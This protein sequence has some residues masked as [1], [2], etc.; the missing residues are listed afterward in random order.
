MD[1]GFSKIDEVEEIKNTLV[2][3]TRI[4]GRSRRTTSTEKPYT[5]ETLWHSQ[6]PQLL[7]IGT[8]VEGS[9]IDQVREEQIQSGE[10]FSIL[11][12]Q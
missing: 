9:R 2:D 10:L 7:L 3:L 6:Q 1:T 12:V 4:S 11:C 5:K 8:L